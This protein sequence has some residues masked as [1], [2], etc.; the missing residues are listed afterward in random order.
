MITSKNPTSSSNVLLELP[1]TF[2]NRSYASAVIEHTATA[3]NNPTN[4]NPPPSRVKELIAERTLSTCN[5]TNKPPGPEMSETFEKYTEP[6]LV[7]SVVRNSSQ[8]VPQ[9]NCRNIHSIFNLY[10]LCHALKVRETLQRA[11]RTKTQILCTECTVECITPKRSVKY[12][13]SCHITVNDK[14]Q[15][16]PKHDGKHQH[17]DVFLG[18]T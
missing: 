15:W 14:P 2:R 11:S 12:D 13:M 8:R 1:R 7:T 3:S 4:P 18:V 17:K 16:T 5:S 10:S 9:D 6:S